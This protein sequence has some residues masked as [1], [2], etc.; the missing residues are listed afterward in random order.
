MEPVLRRLA[1]TD[2]GWESSMPTFP[3][4]MMVLIIEILVITLTNAMSAP[5]RVLL[6]QSLPVMRM[7]LIPRMPMRGIPYLGSDDIGGRISVIRGPA[8]LIAE[9]LIQQSV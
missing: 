5:I 3:L 7:V 1:R 2:F 9:K 6:F 8:I 4:A